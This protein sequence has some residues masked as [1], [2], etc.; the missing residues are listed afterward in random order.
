MIATAIKLNDIKIRQELQPGDLGY[1]AYLH[2]WLYSKE[3]GYGPNFERYVLEG[4]SEVARQYNPSKDRVWMCEHAGK[5]IG[6]LIG[7]HREEDCVQ[8]RYF[9]FLPEYR[10][11][12]LGKKMMD[13]FMEYMQEKNYRKAYLLTTQEQQ[14]AISLYT[15]YGFQLVEEKSS[16]A[17]DKLLVERKY[18]LAISQ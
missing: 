9:I 12:G 7:L 5:I 2:G 1:I 4:L 17:F 14:A 16:T 15:R 18:T 8:L 13:E 6:C 3:L 11:I 10:G